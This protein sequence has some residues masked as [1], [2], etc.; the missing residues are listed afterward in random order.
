MALS[1]WRRATPHARGGV[2][3]AQ[4][5]LLAAP[6]LLISLSDYSSSPAQQEEIGGMPIACLFL[7]LIFIITFLRKC[8]P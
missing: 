2:H 8:T 5:H 3:F 7:V 1:G 4:P 6:R